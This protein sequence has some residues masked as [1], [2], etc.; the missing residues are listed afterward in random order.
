MR[1]LEAIKAQPADSVNNEM[2]ILEELLVRGMPAKDAIVMVI[3]LLMAGIDTVS[4]I[5]PL[6]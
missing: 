1:T 2:S 4:Y 5:L 6:H 3:D